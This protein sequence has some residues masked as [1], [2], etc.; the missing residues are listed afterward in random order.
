MLITKSIISAAAIVCLGAVSLSASDT[1]GFDFEKGAL[2][3][4]KVQSGQW[5][6]V[7]DNTG[8]NV[9][10]CDTPRGGIV[11][12]TKE[13]FTDFELVAGV[14][15]Y[16]G[17]LYEK[18]ILRSPE[19]KG[20]D[21]GY[22]VVLHTAWNDKKRGAYLPKLF[23]YKD[24]KV[25]AAGKL[26]RYSKY[27]KML[28]IRIKAVGNAF[29]GF[30]DDG[31][32]EQKI[33]SWTDEENKYPAGRIGLMANHKATSHFDN[34]RITRGV[35]KTVSKE[36]AAY[37]FEDNFD[38]LPA[39]AFSGNQKWHT[40]CTTKADNKVEVVEEKGRGKVL[41]VYSNRKMTQLIPNVNITEIPYVIEF[42]LK[43]PAAKANA[44]KKTVCGRM[45][46]NFFSEPKAK[47]NN[48]VAHFNDFSY[49]FHVTKTSKSDY[50]PTQS[51]GKDWGHVRIKV[52]GNV[53]AFSARPES[54]KNRK[55]TV[56]Y[57]SIPEFTGSNG[58]IDFT[59]RP[60]WHYETFE[61][62]IDNVKI[63]LLP[64]AERSAYLLK[65]G[66]YQE[67]EKIFHSELFKK[68]AGDKVPAEL[69]KIKAALKK[70]EAVSASDI[71]G[72]QAALKELDQLFV[73]CSAQYRK[74]ESAIFASLFSDKDAYRPLDIS[75]ICNYTPEKRLPA[76]QSFTPLAEVE[77]IPFRVSPVIPYTHQFTL[78]EKSAVKVPVG[79]KSKEIFLL[80]MPQWDLDFLKNGVYPSVSA[81]HND[82]P[83]DRRDLSVSGS[84]E[85]IHQAFQVEIHYENGETERAV[86]L[87]YKKLIPAMDMGKL[88]V[89]SIRPT[90]DQK[91]ASITLCDRMN[92]WSGILYGIT[93]GM[94]APKAMPQTVK[95]IPANKIKEGAG[96]V[97]IAAD[98]IIFESPAYRFSMAKN[99]VLRFT[100]MFNKY[101]ARNMLNGNSGA[102][103]LTGDFTLAKN[104][105]KLNDGKDGVLTPVK[106]QS[107][108]FAYWNIRNVKQNGSDA[109]LF[110]IENSVKNLTGTLT[111]KAGKNEVKLTAVLKNSG[112]KKEKLAVIFPLLKNIIADEY[113]LPLRNGI[114]SNRA[115][116]YYSEY[117]SNMYC[118][119][120]MMSVWD[121][122]QQASL[123]MRVED[124]NG[125]MKVFRFYKKH[126]KIKKLQAFSQLGSRN[127]PYF[128]NEIGDYGNGILLGAQY[129]CIEVE[130]GKEK[131]LPPVSVSVNPGAWKEPL[132]QYADWLKSWCKP[133][134][135]IP[136]KTRKVALCVTGGGL[137]EQSK[138]KSGLEWGGVDLV[139]LYFIHSVDY[140]EVIRKTYIS[141]ILRA[142]KNY[143]S[144]RVPTGLGVYAVEGS[145]LRTETKLFGD[146][147]HK[148]SLVNHKGKYDYFQPLTKDQVLICR[149][150]GEWQNRLAEHVA[151]VARETVPTWVYVDTIGVAGPSMCFNTK[152]DHGDSP[153]EEL[154][155]IAKEM[156]TISAALMKANPTVGLLTEGPGC[157]YLTQ[158]RDGAWSSLRG[159][160]TINNPGNIMFFRYTRPTF[161]FIELGGD[162]VT[163]SKINY[164]N[165]VPVNIYIYRGE[166]R[167]TSTLKP[168]VT[169]YRKY[170]DL[171]TGEDMEPDVSAGD[172][173]KHGVYMNRF[174]NIRNKRV[175]F[176][177][178]NWGHITWKGKLKLDYFPGAKYTVATDGDKVLKH[179]VLKGEKQAEVSFS[180]DPY[181][182]AYIAVTAE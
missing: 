72:Y 108:H 166:D 119:M 126:P 55:E 141:S 80:M 151:L 79:A 8:G 14:R 17:D 36:L 29:E 181:E 13:N 182:V 30:I 54:H 81:T 165:G 149:A 102:L 167:T 138:P 153:A 117:G 177:V 98:R 7:K 162:S 115:L 85:A 164:F 42:D 5:K 128:G 46:L 64:V 134:R 136:E 12:D 11:L 10:T 129:Y 94:K 92:D 61:F 107:P 135:P 1:L 62:W 66:M 100:E 47:K 34:I 15:T 111:V 96:T 148:W 122:N 175:V 41:H 88:S 59:A 74:Y 176:A 31:I 78:A 86:P 143:A 161:K 77:K 132:R 137:D 133:L 127:N 63:S 131:Q 160:E 32:K 114:V 118:M 39:G 48:W 19:G 58:F 163:R 158:F 156:Q 2:T 40:F 49:T 83:I 101:S 150:N 145:Y 90:R 123:T 170:W 67:F 169:G 154:R 91:I 43:V 28:K 105:S 3:G 173:R 180:I 16:K 4:W 25:V 106:P 116:N 144:R 73:Q 124:T 38:D 109:V 57:F 71:A 146:V 171:F 172:I 45:S 125:E 22:M 6:V 139:H 69:A 23:F 68:A 97:E 24:K 50:R 27:D 33:F 53:F 178:A 65:K 84:S 120:Q 70:A 76:F 20:F 142:K 168:L 52:D 9:L 37:P 130:A 75:A 35:V 56:E 179:Q 87:L 147:K 18:M 99:G 103:L 174:G 44:G 110:E 157:D 155:G 60:N 152:H 93:L 159:W 140:P 82:G 104:Y 113:L 89:Y 112:N 121:K 21:C 51:T 26:M 95:L